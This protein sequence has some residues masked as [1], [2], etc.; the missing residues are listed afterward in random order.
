MKTLFT[1]A[2]EDAQLL[3][4]QGSDTSKMVDVMAP[5]ILGFITDKAFFELD[6]NFIADVIEASNLEFTESQAA[7]IIKMLGNEKKKN[8]SSLLSFPYRAYT[9]SILSKLV[10]DISTQPQLK[11]LMKVTPLDESAEGVARYREETEREI[12]E[13]ESEYMS[14]F[15]DIT[16]FRKTIEDAK[17]SEQEKIEELKKRESEEIE[18][19]KKKY[20]E[21]LEKLKYQNEQKKRRIAE[22]NR[23]L[24]NPP[25][26]E[27]HKEEIDNIKKESEKTINDLKNRIMDEYN[28][29]RVLF[30]ELNDIT[31]E[32][33]KEMDEKEKRE[34]EESRPNDRINGYMLPEV[35]KQVHVNKFGQVNLVKLPR[36]VKT[37]FDAIAVRDVKRVREMLQ[38][39]KNLINELTDGR[40]S[41]LMAAL[42]TKDE[43][44]VDTVLEFQPNMNHKD[45]KGRIA[46][47]H[48]V[49]HIQTEII[50][51]IIER[52]QNREVEDND[53]MKPLDLLQKRET[54][55]S[56]LFK[57]CQE[58]GR[59]VE[60]LIKILQQYPDL[61]V[62]PFQ[63]DIRLIHVA[64]DSN[65]YQMID[66]LLEFGADIN[67]QDK[68]GNTAMHYAFRRNNKETVELLL[69]RG[70]NYKL[71]NN[72]GVQGLYWK[73]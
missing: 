35:I 53:K 65:R 36:K 60:E 45:A 13:N 69:E 48:A 6:I 12:K 15:N 4:I 55:Q 42:K 39:N 5:L 73:D 52:T 10:L 23:Y 1:Q 72:E 26:P 22:I 20:A 37:I 18:M 8:V 31:P 41:V 40:I 57:I 62:K 54:L 28:Q 50:K 30:D 29:L 63:E 59:K 3:C 32:M 33:R 34:K 19:L 46:L 21:E 17:N 14:K 7:Y 44:I 49:L 51:K 70:C 25:T 43:E 61:A 2:I 66:K 67:A 47:H 16:N 58:E 38:K 71:T 56:E 68:N 9:A 27:E 11:E 64:A 24:V